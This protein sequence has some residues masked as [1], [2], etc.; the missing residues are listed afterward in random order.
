MYDSLHHL[1]TLIMADR[2]FACSMVTKQSIQGKAKKGDAY[3]SAHA[4]NSAKGE[5]RNQWK[6]T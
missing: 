6:R 5:K 3:N 1:V 2:V 4:P